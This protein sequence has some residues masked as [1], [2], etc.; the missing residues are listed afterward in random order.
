MLMPRTTPLSEFPNHFNSPTP[1][2]E[3]VS[4]GPGR[5]TRS[6]DPSMPILY[7][8]SSISTP[9]SSDQAGDYYVVRSGG[10]ED[11]DCSTLGTWIIGGLEHMLEVPCVFAPCTFG[12]D[13]CGI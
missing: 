12:G 8:C 7:P 10:Q 13:P 3:E 4:D 2:T 5:C 9:P 1:C 6:L 11:L